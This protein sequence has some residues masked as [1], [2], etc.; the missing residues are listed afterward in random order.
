MKKLTLVIIVLMLFIFMGFVS[1]DV[2]MPTVTTVY[3]ENN[4][5]PYNGN[6]EFTVNCYGYS[7]S[8]GPPVE[9]EP[10]TYITENV[11]SFSATCPEYGCKIYE[12]YYLNYRHIVI[13]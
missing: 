5:E 1:A 4:G 10:G 2:I 7:Y 9:K 6:V 3:F 13:I 12:N 11:F 8:P